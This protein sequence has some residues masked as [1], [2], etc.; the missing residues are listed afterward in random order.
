M[1]KGIGYKSCGIRSYEAGSKLPAKIGT[2][3]K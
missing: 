2:S 1:P 3:K